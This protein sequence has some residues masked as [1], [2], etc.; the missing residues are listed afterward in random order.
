FSSKTLLW[1]LAI[2]DVVLPWVS[3]REMVKALRYG[4]RN[5]LDVTVYR[6]YKKGWI[7]F[8]DKQGERFVKLTKGGQIEALLAKARMPQPK[9]WDGKWRIVFF[10]IPESS[11]DKRNLLRSLLK[12]N[13]FRKLQASAYVSPY[14]LNREAIRY[15]T[16]TNLKEFIRI[17]KVEEIDD[18]KDL[19]KMFSLK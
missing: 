12:K 19:R 1:L 18:D 16:E 2:E 4:R 10:D 15:L 6:L 8:I 3:Y 17:V 5:T 14:P 7:K 13:D 9:V 11:K